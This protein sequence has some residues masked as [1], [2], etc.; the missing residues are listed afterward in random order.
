MRRPIVLCL[1]ACAAAAAALALGS[2]LGAQADDTA[3]A[4]HA[5][6]LTA[7][8]SPLAALDARFRKLA[9][10]GACAAG[11]P[12]ARPARRLRAAALKGAAKAPPKVLRRKK[13]SMRRAI[14]LMRAAGGLCAAAQGGGT[15][16]AGLARAGR[17]APGPA[18]APGPG[19]IVDRAQRIG[20]D[21]ALRP[22]R[23]ADRGRR[24]AAAAITNN[25]AGFM[26]SIGVR[27][28]AGS[29][30]RRARAGGATGEP[31]LTR[32]HPPAGSY[33]VYCGVSDHAAQGM[34][35]PLAVGCD[36][37]AAGAAPPPSATATAGGAVRRGS[38]HG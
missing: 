23:S 6:H 25:A 21:A 12:K 28:S 36:G 37:A 24:T 38:R 8:R 17:C 32:R 11:A 34:H 14:A 35:I 31:H 22:R 29:G 1:V 30:V 20:L 19:H 4:G 9:P 33:E 7:A 2:A 27:S 15:P 26:H 5:A 10:A 16:A 18:A 13:A 3:P